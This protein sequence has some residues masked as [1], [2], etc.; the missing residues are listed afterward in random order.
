[1]QKSVT[2]HIHQ[3]SFSCYISYVMQDKQYAKYGDIH[4]LAENK[5]IKRKQ[6]FIILHLNLTDYTYIQWKFHRCTAI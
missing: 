3:G 2:I 1:M 5:Y 4:K 6:S